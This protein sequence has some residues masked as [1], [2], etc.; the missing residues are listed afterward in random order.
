ME[1]RETGDSTPRSKYD[2]DFREV[3][4]VINPADIRN[5]DRVLG[6]IRRRTVTVGEF[7]PVQ[8][9]KLSPLGIELVQP[10]SESPFAKGDQVDLEI[11]LAGQ[12]TRFEGLVVDLIQSAGHAELL[13]IRLSKRHAEEIPVDDRRRTTRWL[14]SDEFFP[15][16]IAPTPGRFDDFVYFKV[17]DISKEGLQLVC[18][19]R[20]KFLIAG[21]R[22]QLVVVFPMGSVT[23]LQVEIARVGITSIGSKDRLV[24]GSKFVELSAFAR[25]VIGQYLIQFGDVESLETLR[26]VGLAPKSVSLGVDFYNLKSEED[27]LEVLELRRLAHELDGNLKAP[28][29]AIDMGD[30]D[31]ARGRIIVG[32]YRGKVVATAR[33]RYNELDEPLEHEAHVVWPKELPRRDQIIEISRVATHP[34]YRR[35]DLLA[36]LFRFTCQ[37]C[38]QPERPWLVLSCLD[39]MVP[40]Y[41]KIGLKETGI[42]HTE[43]IWK[44]DRVLNVLIINISEMVLGR[45]ANPFYWNML[46]KDLA[47]LLIEQQ[48]VNPTGM[49]KVRLMIYRLLGPLADVL[50]YFHRPKRKRK[51]RS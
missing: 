43:P 24:V 1:S 25:Q 14:C 21:M 3:H 23:N 17:R 13:G 2:L 8:V 44:D 48:A 36:A 49:D 41:K 35:N 29:E 11:T 19:L 16:A 26:A 31:D 20:N 39:N 27:Y 37:N 28:V 51:A 38:V 32:K 50:A 15:T 47:E 4:S 45:D 18:S 10:E 7:V 40:F 9:W 34:D 42:R 22:L 12:R 46:W 33:V 30:I 6:R 5:T